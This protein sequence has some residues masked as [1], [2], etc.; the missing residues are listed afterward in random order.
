MF[1]ISISYFSEMN[2]R[3]ILHGN[4]IVFLL[5]DQTK[6]ELIS[7]LK[8]MKDKKEKFIKMDIIPEGLK[9]TDKFSIEHIRY[10]RKMIKDNFDLDLLEGIESIFYDHIVPFF[11]YKQISEITWGS[12]KLHIF[13]IIEEIIEKIKKK[14]E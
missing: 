9:E 6:E 11:N 4:F 8:N 1:Q 12:I 3:D 13:N 10:V 14:L 5:N 2:L 7:F